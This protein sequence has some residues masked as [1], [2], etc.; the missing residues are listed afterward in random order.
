MIFRELLSNSL[1]HAFTSDL[2]KIVIRFHKEGNKYRL[3]FE[4]NGSGI[5]DS[6]TWLKPKSSGLK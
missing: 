1:K 4:D 5:S 3:Q 6:K 2:G